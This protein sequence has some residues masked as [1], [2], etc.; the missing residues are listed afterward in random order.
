LEKAVSVPLNIVE[1]AARSSK[2]NF[3][4]SFYLFLFSYY[5]SL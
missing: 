4:Y 1:G 3:R 5:S 2:S